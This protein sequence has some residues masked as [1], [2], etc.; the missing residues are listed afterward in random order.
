MLLDFKQPAGRLPKVASDQFEVAMQPDRHNSQGAALYTGLTLGTKHA[1]HAV[2]VAAQWIATI[3]VTAYPFSCSS[4]LQK[5]FACCTCSYFTY[6][7]PYVL[8]LSHF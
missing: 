3:L 7:I 2:G 1:G 6:S 8:V 4:L 5:S